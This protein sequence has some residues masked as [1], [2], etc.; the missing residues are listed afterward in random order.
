MKNVLAF[1]FFLS[2]LGLFAQDTLL[3][4][5]ES[6]WGMLTYDMGNMFG[7]IG[8][9]YAR[10]LHWKGKQWKHFGGTVAGTALLY[11]IDDNTSK[12]ISDQRDKIPQ[13]VR[14]YGTFYGGPGNNLI[15]SGAIYTTGLVLKR[16]K[17]RRAGVLMVSSGMAA[18]LLQQ[19]TKFLVGRA[20]PVADLGK[21]TFKP[22]SNKRNFHSFFSGHTAL[23]FSTAYAASKQFKS[24]WIKG[25]IIAVGAVPGISRV[26][27]KQHWLSD[28]A[29]SVAVSIATVECID[30]YL[31]KKYN[32]KYGDR[33]KKLSWN[34]NVGPGTLGVSMHF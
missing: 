6:R 16:E 32:K 11:L 29:F 18:G 20:R 2:S 10:P 9:S 8:H 22:F 5:P 17:L 24:K 28:F 19:A 4:L 1:I 31:D 34:L 27:D 14:D 23:A 13:R 21:D 12:L 3:N 26:W 25:I 33:S 15:L 30:R 7:G